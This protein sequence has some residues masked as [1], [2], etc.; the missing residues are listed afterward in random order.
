[1]YHVMGALLC[2]CVFAL[3]RNRFPKKGN[4]LRN[5]QKEGKGGSSQRAVGQVCGVWGDEMRNHF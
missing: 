3:A 5:R 4:T 1:M 2:M